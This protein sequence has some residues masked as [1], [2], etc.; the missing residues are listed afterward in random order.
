MAEVCAARARARKSRQ[1]RS[2]SS[3][4]PPITDETAVTIRVG[5]PGGSTGG[6]G[7]EE[8][9]NPLFSTSVAPMKK[10]LTL[11]AGALTFTATREALKGVAEVG[12]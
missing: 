4:S 6:C 7:R 1:A 2:G 5:F 9:K 12:L 11:E 3:S 8:V 10:M